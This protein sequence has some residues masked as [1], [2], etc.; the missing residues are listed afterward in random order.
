VL[1]PDVLEAAFLVLDTLALADRDV[2]AAVAQQRLQALS[3]LALQLPVDQLLLQQTVC[4]SWITTMAAAVGNAKQVLESLGGVELQAGQPAAV[5]P[6]GG[7]G[8]P[9]LAASQPLLLSPTAAGGAPGVSPTRKTPLATY[10][11]THPAAGGLESPTAG[12]AAGSGAVGAGSALLTGLPVQPGGLQPDLLL[13]QALGGLSLGAAGTQCGG[14]SPQLVAAPSDGSPA[15]AVP[16]A[17]GGTS[18]VPAAGGAALLGGG[19]LFG[20]AAGVGASSAGGS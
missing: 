4:L 17:G 14:L 15:A 3:N 12:G 18:P 13:T 8:A 19:L 16:P 1:R 5:A 2:A 11:E 10:F 7:G 20:G 6:G 9:L